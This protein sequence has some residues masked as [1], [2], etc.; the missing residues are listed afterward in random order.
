MRALGAD[1]DRVGAVFLTVDPERDTPERLAHYV[2]SFD[3]RLVG[4]SL[5]SPL[6]QRALAAYGVTA[7]RRELGAPDR[8]GEPHYYAVDHTSGFLLIDRKGWVRLRAPH[9]LA[10]DKLAED[11]RRLLAEP[12]PPVEHGLR[13]EPLHARVGPNGIGAAYLRV[14]NP[15]SV[16][17]RLE[18]V[19]GASASRIELHEVRHEG[20]VARMVH[21]PEGFAISAGGELLL[22][23]GGKHLMLFGVSPGADPL[24]VTLHFARSAP[25]EIGLPRFEASALVAAP[26]DGVAR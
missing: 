16:P 15:G 25:I 10:I 23:P 7:T 12:G 24:R 14:S 21:H 13:V 4:V 19:E 18:R 22:S 8:E 1:A 26:V 5:P 11:V 17:D 20:G 3:P 6:H 2:S 9:D